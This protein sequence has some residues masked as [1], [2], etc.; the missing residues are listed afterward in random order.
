[1]FKPPILY[2]SKSFSIDVKNLIKMKISPYF[3]LADY[4]VNNPP[5]LIEQLFNLFPIDFLCSS[6]L[7]RHMKCLTVPKVFLNFRDP[8][9]YFHFGMPCLTCD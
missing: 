7:P 4:S 8:C 6:F 9:Y 3:S 5:F 2:P 1:M